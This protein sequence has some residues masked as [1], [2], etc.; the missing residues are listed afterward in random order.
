MSLAYSFLRIWRHKYVNIYQQQIQNIAIFKILAHS[1]LQLMLVNSMSYKWF[2]CCRMCEK[3]LKDMFLGTNLNTNYKSSSFV[4]IFYILSWWRTTGAMWQIHKH[5]K[6]NSFLSNWK[7]QRKKT[8]LIWIPQDIR[9]PRTEVRVPVY[10][11][12]S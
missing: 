6:C 3:R 12:C 1:F 9:I 8:I 5:E 2:S 11:L 4:S 10:T 7:L